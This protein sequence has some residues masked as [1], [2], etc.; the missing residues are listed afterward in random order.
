MYLRAV[1]STQSLHWLK[2]E[3]MATEPRSLVQEVIHFLL[4]DILWVT[5]KLCHQIHP[6]L[7]QPQLQTIPEIFIRDFST[8]HED[9]GNWVL[10]GVPF[11]ALDRLQ[12]PQNLAARIL[13]CTNPWQHIPPTL[14]RL[15]RL[16][17][18][19]CISFANFSSSSL[20]PS[21]PI[22]HNTSEVS[23]M[24]LPHRGNLQ[25]SPIPTTAGEPLGTFPSLWQPLPMVSTVASQQ[26][27]SN[28]FNS[29]PSLFVSLSKLVHLGVPGCTFTLS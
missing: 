7:P 14:K 17:V 12:Y 13:N 16:P 11:K 10:F 28:E 24:N 25:Y 2:T 8:T 21:W 18:K 29:K 4:S 26:E 6:L 9:H 15:H 3:I 1:L 20:N 27:G 22:H 19:I 23:S 5:H